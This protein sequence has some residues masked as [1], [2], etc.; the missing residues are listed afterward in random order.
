MLSSKEYLCIIKKLMLTFSLYSS[1][2]T[3]PIFLA[4]IP[5]LSTGTITIANA[6]HVLGGRF[7]PKHFTFN[8][9]SSAL[10]R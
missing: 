1:A 6:C 8:P 3:I 4:L 10:R 7:C 2:G 9:H 5:E